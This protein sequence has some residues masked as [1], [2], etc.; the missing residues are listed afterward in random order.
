M[1]AHEKA[2]CVLL[3]TGLLPFSFV[4]RGAPKPGEGRII[5]PVFVVSCREGGIW[6]IL[7][8][9]L[10]DAHQSLV[11]GVAVMVTPHLANSC[12]IG[13]F[14]ESMDELMLLHQQEARQ[15]DWWVRI[16]PSSIASPHTPSR[17]MR[18]INEPGLKVDLPSAC[19]I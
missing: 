6:I 7:S 2:Q 15:Y 17:G 13:I 19:A 8:P 11:N 1:N 4:S 12:M 10:N 14:D 9:Q 16:A 3:G 18:Q 5:A